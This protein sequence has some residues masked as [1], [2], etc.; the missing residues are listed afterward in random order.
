MNNDI[1]CLGAGGLVQ[2]WKPASEEDLLIWRG[3]E[4]RGSAFA[5]KMFS[6]HSCGND[7]ATG[8]AN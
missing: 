6:V 2:Q 1:Q 3:V 7:S 4:K 8:T 5:E